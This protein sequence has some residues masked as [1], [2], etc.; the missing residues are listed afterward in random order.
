[1]KNRAAIAALIWMMVNAV[2]FGIGAVTVLTVPSLKADAS[3]WLPVVI[4]VSFLIS[5]FIGWALAPRLTARWERE[6][7]NTVL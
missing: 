4:V 6:H 5:P 1:M 3:Y 2:L 7:P